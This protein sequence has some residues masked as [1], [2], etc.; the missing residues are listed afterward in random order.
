LDDH[1]RHGASMTNSAFRRN[2]A[3]FLGIALS[4]D[5]KSRRYLPGASDAARVWDWIS[6]CEI[7]WIECA[8]E[9]DA[10]LLEASL[11]AESKPPLTK[12]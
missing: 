1:L 8:T 4:A 2:V 6:G 12:L 9:L 5:I 7:A 11:K 10:L 3:A